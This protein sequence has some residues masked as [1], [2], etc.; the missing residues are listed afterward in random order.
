M[1][2]LGS[3]HVV[4]SDDP[5]PARESPHHE[6]RQGKKREDVR[7]EIDAKPGGLQYPAQFSQSIA[8][9][10]SR[11]VILYGPE[12]AV[13]WDTDVEPPSRSQLAAQ[14]PQKRCVVFEVFEHIEE[15]RRRKTPIPEI[16]LLQRR[17]NY[18]VDTSLPR[19]ARPV[20][21]RLNEHHLEPGLGQPPRH[22]TVSATDV[23]N[24]SLWREIAHC[25][26][27]APVAVGKPEGVFFDSQ[28]IA[29]TFVR[30]RD[31]IDLSATSEP[32][33]PVLSSLK[34]GNLCEI[35]FHASS[36]S[37]TLRAAVRSTIVR[38]NPNRP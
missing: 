30:I 14:L 22:E 38:Q 9:E 15:T 12:E 2:S 21:P 36:P 23:E 31:P 3:P 37:Y 35:Q 34:I 18:V 1:L 27:N 13:R 5:Q 10:M 7:G 24:C 29:I 19:V 6:N 25:R 26:G 8:P 20:F 17:T 33:N 32:P 28:A 11:M 4:L 16:R